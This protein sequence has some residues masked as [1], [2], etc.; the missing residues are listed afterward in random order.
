MKK[1]ILFFVIASV[2]I[3]DNVSSILR[4]LN[5]IPHAAQMSIF[6]F[7]SNYFSTFRNTTG[8]RRRAFRSPS[9]GFSLHPSSLCVRPTSQAVVGQRTN[10]ACRGGRTFCLQTYLSFCLCRCLSECL[11]LYLIC[12]IYLL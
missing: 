1:F 3:K 9:V 10:L 12:E 6:S 11:S 8:C 7:S 4:V 5:A 2:I